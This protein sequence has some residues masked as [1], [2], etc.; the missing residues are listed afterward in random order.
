MHGNIS[1][2]NL[3][4]AE[5]LLRFLVAWLAYHILGT[6]QAMAR[7]IKEIQSGM[8]HEEAYARHERLIDGAMEPIV[9][10][11][12]ELFHQI[13]ERNRQ[14]VRLNESLETKVAERTGELSKA[15]AEL[16]AVVAKLEEEKLASLRLSR[17]L[18]GANRRLHEMSMTDVFTGLPNRRHAISRLEDEWQGALAKGTPLS[19][20]MIDADGFKQINDNYGHDAGDA[21]LKALAR[22]LLHSVRSDDAV[23]RLGG[24][25]FLVICPRTPLEGAFH[26]AEEMRLAVN[27]MRVDVNGGQWLGSISVGV[28]VGTDAMPLP[29]HLLKAADNAVYIAKRRGRNCVATT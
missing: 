19:C 16:V 7:Q 3:A 14:L 22:E 2:T 20:M 12:N 11:L 9:T 4:G 18:E 10:A 8:T 24:D 15:N 28:A 5:N 29:E 23:C 26:L 6:D 13:S 25:E 21:V 1:A 27:R 17:E